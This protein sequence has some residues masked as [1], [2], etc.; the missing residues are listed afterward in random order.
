MSLVLIEGPAGSGKTTKLVEQVAEAL[1]KA[2]LTEA[3][4]VLGL[5]AFHGS[6][7]RM[8]ATLSSVPGIGIPFC[9]TIDSFAWHLLKRWRSL[10]SHLGLTPNQEDFEYTAESAITLLKQPHVATW[11]LSSFPLLVLDEL[12]DCK[13]AKLNLLIELSYITKSYAAADAFQDLDGSDRCAAIE[14]AQAHGEIQHLTGNHRT[15]TKGILDAARALRTGESCTLKGVGFDVQAIRAAPI[16]GAATAWKVKSWQK[17]GTIAILS[18]TSPARSAFVKKVVNWLSSNSAKSGKSDITAGPYKTDW[19]SNDREL[20]DQILQKFGENGNPILSCDELMKR[21]TSTSDLDVVDWIRH[22]KYVLGR[23]EVT[24]PELGNAVKDIVRRRR[25]FASGENQYRSAMTI[26]QAKNREFDSVIVLW[27][28]AIKAD[29]E[30]ARRLLYNAITRAKK[31][32]IVFV[33]DPTGK[34]LQ[35]DPFS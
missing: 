31:R 14:W 2:P 27:P 9:Q 30:R 25:V 4:R 24:Y 10:A 8:L 3:Q 18:P 26:H 5:T 23:L 15:D 13:G 32:A 22:Q 7:K 12:Q 1:A 35:E 17:D 28:L 19:E 21:L 6:R 34:R 33:E 20:S 11:V 29:K 16:A